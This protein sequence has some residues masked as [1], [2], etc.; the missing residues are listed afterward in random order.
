MVIEDPRDKQTLYVGTDL[1]VYVTT[2]GGETWH[3]LC[4]GLPALRV[5]DLFV[6]PETY[7]LVAGTHGRGVYML[8]V[9]TVKRQ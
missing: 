8:D 7:E 9:K 2:T 4:K 1:G 6:H 5:F 3:S